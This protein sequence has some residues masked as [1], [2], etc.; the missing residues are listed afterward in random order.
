MAEKIRF[1]CT[2][3]KSLSADPK[4][5]GR[6]AKCPRCGEVA[7]VPVMGVALPELEDLEL[8]VVLE[9]GAWQSASSGQANPPPVPRPTAQTT[10]GTVY[11]QLPAMG[12]PKEPI[13]SIW[14]EE[15]DAE[16]QRELANVCPGCGTSMSD[17]AVVC[18][19]CGYNKQTGKKTPAATGGATPSSRPAESRATG[20]LVG[21]I[22]SI[23][24]LAAA[25]MLAGCAFISFGM[26]LASAM[27][28]MLLV[29]FA[30]GMFLVGGLS[31]S[32]GRR[33]L[34]YNV[35]LN[36]VS[37]PFGFSVMRHSYH[38]PS[39][40]ARRRTNRGWKLFG[41]GIVLIFCGVFAVAMHRANGNAPR[42]RPGVNNDNFPGWRPPRVR[43][44]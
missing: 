31:D 18:L 19:A 28:G 11:P 2:C 38:T 5:A 21:N 13:S 3:G 40:K 8:K 25:L 23:A 15:A 27:I 22:F 1:T 17:P 33:N 16:R 32:S 20:N 42:A 36:I 39:A 12:R 29:I 14:A 9:G 43:I 26:A 24:L 35:L 4:M 30:L 44:R 34:L 6:K 7:R 41:I 37:L 10:P